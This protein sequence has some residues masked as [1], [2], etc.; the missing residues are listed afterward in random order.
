[1]GYWYDKDFLKK[2]SPMT[3][4]LVFYGWHKV[5]ASMVV[6]LTNGFPMKHPSLGQG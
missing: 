2:L 5:F 4:N 3:G 1:M 6:S